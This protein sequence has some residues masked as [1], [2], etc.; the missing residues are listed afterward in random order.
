MI[1]A[2][3]KGETPRS[4]RGGRPK[5]RGLA[6]IAGLLGVL[7]LALAWVG[8][9]GL[10]ARRHLEQARSGVADVRSHLLAGDS[11]QAAAALAEGQGL[12]LI[13]ISEPTR[14]GMISYA[15]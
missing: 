15:V 13:H 2:L 11:T 7:L 3:A 6:S 10:L 9:R 1:M 4:R 14:L 12:S 8:V 5:R